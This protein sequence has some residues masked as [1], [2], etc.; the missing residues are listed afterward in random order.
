MKPTCIATGL[1]I[2]PSAAVVDAYKVGM[3]KV[4]LWKELSLD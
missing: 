3:E 1:G 4:A 2:L